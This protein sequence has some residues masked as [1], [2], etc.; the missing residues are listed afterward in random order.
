MTYGNYF[1]EIISTKHCPH[2]SSKAHF[3]TIIHCNTITSGHFSKGVYRLTIFDKE[4]ST[5]LAWTGPLATNYF[6]IN[7]G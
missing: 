7:F 2:K 6:V 3:Y 1:S 4:T 5:C